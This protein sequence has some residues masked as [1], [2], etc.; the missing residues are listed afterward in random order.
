MATNNKQSAT[1]KE[2]D[3]SKHQPKSGVIDGVG[4]VGGSSGAGGLRAKAGYVGE[5]SG[6]DADL[7]SEEIPMPGSTGKGG[8][9]SARQGHSEG[10]MSGKNRGPDS[11]SE[12]SRSDGT[13]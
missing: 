4:G 7:D 11:E 1:D 10:G 6:I 9:A 3:D 2:R 8:P 12:P 13:A 5:I